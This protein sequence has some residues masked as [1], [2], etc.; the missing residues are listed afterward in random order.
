MTA[1]RMPP[2]GSNELDQE[3]LALIGQ[4]I[5]SLTPAKNYIHSG[6]GIPNR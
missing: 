5:D 4:W 1:Y 3:G 6:S 2:L